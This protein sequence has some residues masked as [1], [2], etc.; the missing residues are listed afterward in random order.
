MRT[1]GTHEVKVMVPERGGVQYNAGGW[2]T[3]HEVTKER[4][5]GVI[6]LQK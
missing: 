5:Y 4:I 6:L 1:K 3:L 2:K